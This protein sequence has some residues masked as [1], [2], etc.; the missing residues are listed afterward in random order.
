MRVLAAALG[1]MLLPAVTSAQ[2]VSGIQAASGKTYQLGTLGNGQTVYIDRTYT[3]SSVPV[4]LVGAEYIRTA[5]DDKGLFNAA[6]LT[7][8]LSGP[9]TVLV[10]FD[11][12]MS[13]PAWLASFMDRG[14]N[15]VTTDATLSLV[16]SSFPAGSVVLGG[17]E[18][19]SGNGS[20]YSVV[21][22]PD[23]EPPP[24]PLVIFGLVDV[25]AICSDVD[26]AG[27][28]LPC[29]SVRILLNGSEILS[30]DT[31][32]PF[33][34]LWNTTQLADGVYSLTGEAVDLVGNVGVSEPLLVE[35]DNATI[36]PDVLP[37]SIQI[38]VLP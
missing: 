18:N 28:P 6:F 17:N 23:S 3:F 11:D 20:M 25:S 31:A 27:N 13:Q 19:A 10:A 8:N 22:V 7:F 26:D 5:N 33:E 14:D 30:P 34:W 9:A 2:L 29:A 35:I 4:D 21:V 32:E 38:Q 36:L 24:D 15:L 12:R 37:P 16:E 1:L